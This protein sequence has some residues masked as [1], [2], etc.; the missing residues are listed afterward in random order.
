MSK[1]ELVYWHGK[2]MSVPKDRSNKNWYKCEHCGR[3]FPARACDRMRGWARF[4]S[5]SCAWKHRHQ[6]KEEE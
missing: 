3:E 4:C 2:V 6:K 5:K 1:F